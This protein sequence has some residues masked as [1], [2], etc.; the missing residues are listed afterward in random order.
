MCDID[1][2]PAEV[3]KETTRKARKDHQCRCCKRTIR[4][5]EEYVVVFSIFEGE[6][7]SQK[8]CA[9]CDKERHDFAAHDGHCLSMPSHF[10][11][12][13]SDC[14]GDSYRSYDDDEPIYD[15]ETVAWID[16]RDRIEARRPARAA[17]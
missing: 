16:M 13:L 15:A 12:M 2:E 7:D 14:I 1:L 4:K 10:R 9:H 17:S 6:A 5:G 3:W 8:C 11:E